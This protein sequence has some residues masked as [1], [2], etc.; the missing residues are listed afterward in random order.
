M[1]V[2]SFHFRVPRFRFGLSAVLVFIALVATSLGAYRYQTCFVE[3]T[4]P[5]SDIL[6]ERANCDSLLALIELAVSPNTWSTVGGSGSIE[7]SEDR[8][9]LVISQT[10]AV[11]QEVRR[12]IQAVHADGFAAVW[13]TELDGL[14]VCMNCGSL[15][16]RLV[17]LT[18]LDE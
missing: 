13:N 8:V 12:L 5:V 15:G 16:C 11:H 10:G 4:Y 14:S 18:P 3:R 1:T 9:S 7:V 17:P 6:T 2:L